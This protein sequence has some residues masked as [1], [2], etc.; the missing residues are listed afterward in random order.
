MTRA[1]IIGVAGASGGV[2]A[3]VFTV[4]LGYRA[5]RRGVTTVCV[6]AR[7]LGGG[8]DVVLGVDHER[9]VRW[10]ALQRAAGRLDGAALLT[11]LP[12]V[13]GLAILSHDRGA[14]PEVQ[15]DSLRSVI[16]GLADCVDLLVIDLPA[17]V[18]PS[19]GWWLQLIDDGLLVV[20]ASP[21]ALAGAGAFAGSMP[22]DACRWWLVQRTPPRAA[23]LGET[24]A[25]ALGLPLL[26]EVTDDG[27]VV[28]DLRRGR[29]PGRRG[30]LAQ[31]ADKALGV[32]TRQVR[33]SA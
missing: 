3:S 16:L 8:L 26:V 1:R 23:G 10:P 32:L 28:T 13:D 27:R 29:T 21:A 20:G 6:D 30:L 22:D 7:P 12:T 5:C 15:R 33:R 17:R 18:D 31:V 2:G 25:A 4:A 24:V 11:E 19:F 14:L 9:G